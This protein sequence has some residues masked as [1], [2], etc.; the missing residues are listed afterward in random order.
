M[1]VNLSPRVPSVLKMRRNQEL[2]LTETK[3]CFGTRQS[4]QKDIRHESGRPGYVG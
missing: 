2:A 3:T 4:T 1:F